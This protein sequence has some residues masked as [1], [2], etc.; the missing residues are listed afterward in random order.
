MTF[1][2]N[3]Y[4]LFQAESNQEEVKHLM[5]LSHDL[6]LLEDGLS[7][8][9]YTVLNTEMNPLYTR[10]LVKLPKPEELIKKDLYSED[11]G[12]F[13]GIFRYGM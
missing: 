3:E 12:K 8:V 4:L 5:H 7:T 10:I 11:S 6:K 9:A 13:C 1:V 2:L